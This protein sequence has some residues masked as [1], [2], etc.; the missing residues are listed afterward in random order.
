MKRG[1]II[2]GIV[3]LLLLVDGVYLVLSNNQVGGDQGAFTGN[4]NIV[5]SPGTIVLASGGFLA[6]GA[7]IMWI[8]ALRRQGQPPRERAQPREAKSQA[9]AGQGNVAEEHGNQRQ[10]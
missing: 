6:V 4:P 2:F 7:L 5:L 3:A 10:S 1:S 9:H 8:V